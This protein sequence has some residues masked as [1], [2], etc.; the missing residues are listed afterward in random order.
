MVVTVPGRF[1]DVAAAV[2][3]N[4]EGVIEVKLTLTTDH[5]REMKNRISV[6]HGVED[7][8]AI[9]DVGGDTG[10]AVRFTLGKVRVE[11]HD[12]IDRF[13]RAGRPD[14]AALLLELLAET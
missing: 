4:A 3:I 7:R 10:C 5:G 9:R 11:E 12:F 2:E 13:C 1:E 14:E 8:F 6:C